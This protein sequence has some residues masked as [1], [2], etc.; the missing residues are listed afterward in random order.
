[1]QRCLEKDPKRRL[2]DIGDAWQLLDDVPEAPTAKSGVRWK[3]AAGVLVVISAVSLWA[4]WRATRPVETSPPP[5]VRLDLDLGPDVSLGSS[6][7]PAVILS[8]DGALLIGVIP[9]H[10]LPHAE[11]AEGQRRRARGRW[12]SQRTGR[13][14]FR[15][16]RWV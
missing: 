1:L 13:Q 2:R 7:G 16:E 6:T 8:P 14:A 3:I 11:P 9:T 5:A 10:L 15:R 4:L 12:R